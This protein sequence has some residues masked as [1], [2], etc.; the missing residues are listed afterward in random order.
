[1]YKITPKPGRTTAS[2]D[3]SSSENERLQAVDMVRSISILLV[4]AF[5]L[6][7]TYFYQELP[8]QPYWLEWVWFKTS[9]N[10]EYGVLMFFVVSGFLITR[11]IALQPPG[12]FKPDLRKF[13]FRRIGRILPLFLLI[14]AVNSLYS[15]QEL[16]GLH[17]QL[18]SV[19]HPLF[20]VS[21]A[22][23]SFNWYRAFGPS[24]SPGFGLHWDILW[25]LSVE[26]QFYL[27][28]PLFLCGLRNKRNLFLFFLFFI[29]LGPWVRAVGVYHYLHNDY[30]KMNSFAL[31]DLIAMG[32]LLYL[33]VE[34]FGPTLRKKPRWCL[35][36]L[37]AGL[38]LFL[39]IYLQTVAKAMFQ[40]KIWGPS[41]IGLSVFLCLL[42]G[43][44]L[45]VFELN[46]LR[47]LTL[48]GKLSYG[49]Y[50]WH[51]LVLYCLL[52]FLKKYNEWPDFLIFI[53]LGTTVAWLSY[54]FFEQPAN[55]WVRKTFNPGAKKGAY[56]HLPGTG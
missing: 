16:M 15:F 11:L 56:G 35:L 34:R 21:L 42:G 14:L 6:G 2:T 39:E 1:L 27:F 53:L 40:L 19:F 32:G 37:S 46:R 44:H 4:L 5:H 33:T 43:L 18:S 22:T 30:W 10:G 36:F 3:L 52:T 25:S 26:E 31:F 17:L 51:I 12:L 8:A 7:L 9:A 28:Y 23:F 20:W 47:F 55:L 13:Y 38:F 49:I 54:R 48:P 50:L 45:K 29:L 41:A 24:P